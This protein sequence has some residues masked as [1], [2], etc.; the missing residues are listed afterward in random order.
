MLQG[1]RQNAVHVLDQE[2]TRIEYIYPS[3]V[4]RKESRCPGIQQA[5]TSSGRG[6]RLARRPACKQQQLALAETQIGAHLLRHQ[7]L[8][9]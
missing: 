8:K 6:E 5:L 9:P 1:C 3:Q 7:I 2:G 4:S